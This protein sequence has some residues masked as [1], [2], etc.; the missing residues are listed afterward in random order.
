MK[1]PS[2][3]DFPADGPGTPHSPAVRTPKK[4]GSLLLTP[5]SGEL[6]RWRS[7][8][9]GAEFEGG[10]IA[11]Q[12]KLVGGQMN[13]DFIGAVQVSQVRGKACLSKILPSGRGATIQLFI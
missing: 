3:E 9:H 10:E 7:V 11:M 13:V 5:S 12:A 2:F 6:A 1:S 4:Y 8:D